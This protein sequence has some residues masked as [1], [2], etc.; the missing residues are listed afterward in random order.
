MESL[1]S[2]QSVIDWSINYI[3]G[4]DVWKDIPIK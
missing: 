4:L 2:I 3:T 1:L